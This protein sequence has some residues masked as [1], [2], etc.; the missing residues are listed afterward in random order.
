MQVVGLIP[1]LGPFCVPVSAWL[2]SGFPVLVP[3]SKNIHVR[4]AEHSE[5]SVGLHVFVNDC[6]SRGP[7]M[8]WQLVRGRHPAVAL[9]QA[10]IGSS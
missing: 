2:P 8:S 3:Q 10:G 4:S 5:L 6:L 1:G 9:R 7:A